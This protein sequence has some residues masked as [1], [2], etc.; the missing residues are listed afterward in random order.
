MFR[1]GMKSKPKGGISIAWTIDRRLFAGRSWRD[2]KKGSEREREGCIHLWGSIVV[3]TSCARYVEGV[4]DRL[5]WPRHRSNK[6]SHNGRTPGTLDGWIAGLVMFRGEGVG[7]PRRHRRKGGLTALDILPATRG[8]HQWDSMRDHVRP[9]RYT[10]KSV[11]RFRVL[12]RVSIPPCS[13]V[14][15]YTLVIV[16]VQ[17]FYSFVLLFLGIGGGI[18][19]VELVTLRFFLSWRNI[20]VIIIVFGNI[21]LKYGIRNLKN[22]IDWKIFGYFSFRNS[23]SNSRLIVLRY[24]LV[25]VNNHE[26]KSDFKI[27]RFSRVFRSC[28]SSTFPR[29][30]ILMLFNFPYVITI[31]PR[32]SFFQEKI[33]KKL[34]YFKVQSNVSCTPFFF[35]L[36]WNTTSIYHFVLITLSCRDLVSLRKFSTARFRSEKKYQKSELV[37][38]VV[39]GGG[40]GGWSFNARLFSR[41]DS[42]PVRRFFDCMEIL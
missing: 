21:R 16:V 2:C 18:R 28:L 26:R 36:S 13:H 42:F 1:R 5:M 39:H 27:H 30:S 34:F 17:S 7:G 12:S 4:R 8:Y 9:P 10:R 25:E 35:L 14:S 3:C 6:A 38:R 19:I 40:G 32:E 23:S 33:L 31:F 20:I 37:P 24:C 41:Y 11:V 15:S 22:F 29:R